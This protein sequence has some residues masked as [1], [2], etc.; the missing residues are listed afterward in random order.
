[1]QPVLLARHEKKKKRRSRQ[2]QEDELPPMALKK[3]SAPPVW[4]ELMDSRGMTVQDRV[5]VRS[6]FDV[7]GDTE[8]T[9]LKVPSGHRP[10][11]RTH[12]D[13]WQLWAAEQSP[14][15]GREIC[16]QEIA[17]WFIEEQFPSVG[18]DG[19]LGQRLKEGVAS[20]QSGTSPRE[21]ALILME[22]S[23]Q[24]GS[25]IRPTDLLDL[26]MAVSAP[27]G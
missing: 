4:Q 22:L 20:I 19:S 26:L 11:H 3:P 16:W 27:S 25:V 15:Y 13:E 6:I 17:Y 12:R 21:V 5:R 10:T 18:N 14:K 2:E 24:Y 23:R 1:M 8:L 7:M 9:D